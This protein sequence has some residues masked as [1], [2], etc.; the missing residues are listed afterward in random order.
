MQ[1]SPGKLC[2]YGL[3]TRSIRSIDV[4]SPLLVLVVPVDQI[5]YALLE[6][7]L[8]L[9]IE[10]AYRLADVCPGG[11]PVGR[12]ST[13]CPWDSNNSATLDPM[14]PALPVTR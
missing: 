2:I 14:K 12:V 10:Q 6:G 8:R 3:G 13:C 9:P 4:A 1:Q 5:P 7:G 11:G